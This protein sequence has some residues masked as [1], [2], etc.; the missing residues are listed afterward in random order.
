MAITNIYFFQSE[1]LQNLPKLG[2]LVCCTKKNLA[3][4]PRRRRR[5]LQNFELKKKFFGRRRRRRRKN[6]SLGHRGPIQ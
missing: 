3:T 6:A 5:P 1:A 4:L 2:F